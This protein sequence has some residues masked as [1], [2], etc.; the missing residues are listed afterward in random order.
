MAADNHEQKD[1]DHSVGSVIVIG[2]R[3]CVEQAKTLLQ[4]HFSSIEDISAVE[5]EASALDMAL[6][7]LL[8]KQ[9]FD[10]FGGMRSVVGVKFVC[11]RAETLI[12]S[13]SYCVFRCGNT[14][15][16]SPFSQAWCWTSD[17]VWAWGAN[18]VR[19]CRVLGFV[20]ACRVLGRYAR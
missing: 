7:Q 12:A 11:C 16:R 9:P 3:D 17:A 8:T 5:R 20:W 2:L 15:Q 14:T 10:R 1:T 6:S 4:Y 13:M 18:S 19:A